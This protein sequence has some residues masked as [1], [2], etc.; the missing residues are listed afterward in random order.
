MKI[1]IEKDEI[2]EIETPLNTYV[3]QIYRYN[4]RDESMD[5]SKY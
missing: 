2:L 3:I 4:T 1:K 5:I